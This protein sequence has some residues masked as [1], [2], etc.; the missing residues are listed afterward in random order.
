MSYLSRWQTGCFHR[1]LDLLL[2]VFVL[3]EHTHNTE[4]IRNK[5]SNTHVKTH[6]NKPKYETKDSLKMISG[7]SESYIIAELGSALGY[8][9]ILGA[10][11]KI[12][13]LNDLNVFDLN[14]LT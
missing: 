11:F 1:F 6:A 3:P 4:N 12:Y 8:P 2:V 5:I 10:F 7:I 14:T 13:F 9:L